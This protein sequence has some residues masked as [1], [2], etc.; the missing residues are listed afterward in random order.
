MIDATAF[1]SELARH[2][3]ADPCADD[4][5]YCADIVAV[6][7]RLKVIEDDDWPLAEIVGGESGGA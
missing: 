1:V 3:S 5:P 2:Y 6:D 7:G 4:C